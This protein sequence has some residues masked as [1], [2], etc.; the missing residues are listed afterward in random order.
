LPDGREVLV[1]DEKSSTSQGMQWITAGI[2]LTCGGICTAALVSGRVTSNTVFWEA[3]FVAVLG[4]LTGTA[5]LIVALLMRQGSE[6][7]EPSTDGSGLQAVDTGRREIVISE[8][9]TE[10]WWLEKQS[11]SIRQKPIGLW[12]GTAIALV[13]DRGYRIVLCCL[14][15]EDETHSWLAHS[16]SWVRGLTVRTVPEGRYLGWIRGIP[17]AQ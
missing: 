16:P 2:L 5:V 6:Q 11:V 8:G 9:P 12:R 17:T 4:N 14:S 10:E 7:L 13:H 15:S 1:D 3:A